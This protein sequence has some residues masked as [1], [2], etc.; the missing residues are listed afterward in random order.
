[1]TVIGGCTSLRFSLSVRV[2]RV[3]PAPSP[4]VVRT[5]SG[6]G[7]LRRDLEIGERSRQVNRADREP[8]A[9]G[10]GRSYAA[11]E[12]S[13]V[14]PNS[15]RSRTIVPAAAVGLGSGATR[16]SAMWGRPRL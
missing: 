4:P 8:D 1:M 6:G 2:V 11:R 7:R 3:D 12:Y 16:L 15:F 13:V 9:A 5:K 10:G 14:R